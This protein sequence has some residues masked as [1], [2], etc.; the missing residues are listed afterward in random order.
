MILIQQIEDFNTNSY[1]GV[2]TPAEANSLTTTDQT[3]DYHVLVGIAKQLQVVIIFLCI[4]LNT[5]SCVCIPL[6]I[7][8]VKV[9]IVQCLGTWANCTHMY[10]WFSH[11]LYR[12][13]SP[14]SPMT[15]LEMRRLGL[16][17]CLLLLRD[18]MNLIRSM[19]SH[20]GSQPVWRMS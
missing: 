7:Y 18:I 2:E 4:P 19:R 1:V 11:A 14:H 12:N 17:S 3:G 9:I 6:V 13:A 15:M 8:I 20:I 16:E 10:V 5:S